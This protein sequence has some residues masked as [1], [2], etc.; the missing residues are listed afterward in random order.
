MDGTSGAV[1]TTDSG[2]KRRIFTFDHVGEKR[3]GRLNPAVAALNQTQPVGTF[4][5][6]E[7][8][9]SYEEMADYFKLPSPPIV[10]PEGLDYPS[11]GYTRK[12]DVSYPSDGIVGPETPGS[13]TAA[14]MMWK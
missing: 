6:Q 8:I 1:S 10:S 4:G 9:Q 7:Q 14:A 5:R 12:I 2:E 13:A 11:I 3:Q